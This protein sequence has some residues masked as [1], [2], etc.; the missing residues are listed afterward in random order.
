MNYQKEIEELKQNSYYLFKN[1]FPKEKINL[2]AKYAEKNYIEEHMTAIRSGV[3]PACFSEKAPFPKNSKDKIIEAMAQKSPLDM[4]TLQGSMSAAAKLSDHFLD[5]FR[6]KKLIDFFS[7]L[8]ESKNLYIHLPPWLRVVHPNF[9]FAH[10]PPHNDISYFQNFKHRDVNKIGSKASFY[11]IWIPLK[12]TW[13]VDGGLAVYEKEKSNTIIK[14]PQMLNKKNKFWIESMASEGSSPIC[15]KFEVGDFIVFEPELIHGSAKVSGKS[16]DFR[17]SMDERIF[18]EDTLTSRFYM[19]IIT[20]ER[21]E[22]GTGP[23][24]FNE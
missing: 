3:L 16:K 4:P 11:S 14:T 6:E 18:G 20:G 9:E 22:P 24:A 2:A 21:Y 17:I 5:L 1:A 8:L 23:C 15:P 12:A 10:V 19:N 7:N 13:G